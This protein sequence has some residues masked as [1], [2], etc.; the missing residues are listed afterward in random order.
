MG[1]SMDSSG[2]TMDSQCP[3]TLLHKLWQLPAFQ[4]PKKWHQMTRTRAFMIFYDL[5]WAFVHGSCFLFCSDVLFILLCKSQQPNAVRMQLPCQE[6]VREVRVEIYIIRYL[7]AQCLR[8]AS[9]CQLSWFKPPLESPDLLHFATECIWMYIIWY[10]LNLFHVGTCCFLSA[11]CLPEETKRCM[12]IWW[13]RNTW[14][15]PNST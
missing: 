2:I 11:S 14:G 1:I 5:L 15:L 13:S 3:Q 6:H 8:S 7:T 4:S 10:N 9:M 12:K